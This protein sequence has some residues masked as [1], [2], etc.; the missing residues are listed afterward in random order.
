M[1][2]KKYAKITLYRKQ[3]ITDQVNKYAKQI[4]IM[5]EQIPRIVLTTREVMEMPIEQ[6]KGRRTSAY[7]HLGVCYY[8]AR[9]IF[10]NARKLVTKENLRY[11]IA[12]E[13]VHY[14]FGYLSHGRKFE[15]RVKEILKG[16]TFDVKDIKVKESKQ[17]D[18]DEYNNYENIST[19]EIIN[20][21]RIKQILA[22]YEEMKK[23]FVETTKYVQSVLQ[24]EGQK[25]LDFWLN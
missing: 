8:N 14:R 23:K 17:R 22:T 13:L 6:T 20:N 9:T 18:E 24:A 15:K 12:H 25:G 16:K 5:D 21:N 19:D 10:I 7:K 11:T 4:G 1:R 3:F 2:K